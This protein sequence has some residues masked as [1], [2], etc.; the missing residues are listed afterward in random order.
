MSLFI[1]RWKNKISIGVLLLQSPIH[2]F[3]SKNIFVESLSQDLRTHDLKEQNIFFFCFKAK[4]LKTADG[5][6]SA[7][8]TSNINSEL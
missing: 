2:F 5:N 4:E 1:V 6:F 7:L 3:V 8:H